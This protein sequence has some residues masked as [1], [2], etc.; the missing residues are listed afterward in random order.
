MTNIRRSSAVVALGLATMLAGIAQ[1]QTVRG[2]AVYGSLNSGSRP[3][4]GGQ[5]FLVEGKLPPFENQD[6]AVPIG[7][8]GNQHSPR[9]LLH[10]SRT[11]PCSAESCRHRIERETI[12]DGNG[13]FEITGLR[14]GDYGVVVVSDHVSGAVWSSSFTLM[15]RSTANVSAKFRGVE[16]RRRVF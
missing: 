10:K 6:I 11:G 15:E 7:I 9:E 13:N 12:A 4:T 8:T 2:T 3:D 16:L 5:V 1:A 14:P